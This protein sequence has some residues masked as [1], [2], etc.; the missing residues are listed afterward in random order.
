MISI[1]DIEKVYE[2]IDREVTLA[3]LRLT[4]NKRLQKSL[5]ADWLFMRDTFKKVCLCAVKAEGIFKDT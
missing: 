5:I 3:E 4:S 1:R 2:I